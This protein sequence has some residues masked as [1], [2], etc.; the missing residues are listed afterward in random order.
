VAQAAEVQTLRA[1][2]DKLKEF[3]AKVMGMTIAMNSIAI[4]IGWLISTVR[5][6]Q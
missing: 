3:R 2:V 1:E 6:A 5:A 4:V